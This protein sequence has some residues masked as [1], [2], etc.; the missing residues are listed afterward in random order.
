MLAPGLLATVA[1]GQAPGAL[2]VAGS[3]LMAV[4]TLAG[5]WLAV[6]RRGRHQVWLGAAAGALLVIALLH[7][8]PDA[9]FAAN[10]AGLWPLAMPCVAVGSF[11]LAGL[12]ARC[13]CWCGASKQHTAGAGAALALAVHRFLDGLALG[14]AA[15]VTVAGALA[16]HAAAE[17]LAA[18]ALLR[19]RPRQ[20]AAWLAAMCLSP[21]VGAAI[22]IAH[23]LPS[24]AEPLLLALAAGVVAQAARISLAASWQAA[25]GRRLAPAT[26]ASFLAAAAITALAVHAV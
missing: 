21:G 1:S 3:V 10:A 16:V 25:G 7:L 4:A 15:S 9:W 20:A 19:A 18:G 12:A 24:A 23:P 2:V 6:R 14:V 5:A 26:A 17:G 22:S 11:V 8:L 13:G